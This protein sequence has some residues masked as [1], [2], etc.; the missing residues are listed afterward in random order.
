MQ[1]ETVNRRN[2]AEEIR[3]REET[4]KLNENAAV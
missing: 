2:D 3:R 1:N 4:A